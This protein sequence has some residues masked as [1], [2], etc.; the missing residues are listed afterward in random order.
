MSRVVVRLSDFAVRSAL[1]LPGNAALVAAGTER[2]LTIP[3]HAQDLVLTV[4]LPDAPE[5]A[6]A[7]MPVYTNSGHRDP[8]ELTGW[9]WYR[10]DGSEITPE[11]QPA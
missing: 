10:E 1:R 9:H 3:D 4:D 7:A 11:G 6:V 2:L 5:G 8:I